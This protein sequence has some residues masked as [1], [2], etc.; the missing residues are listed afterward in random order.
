MREK[1]WI[2]TSQERILTV[3]NTLVD[4][5]YVSTVLNSKF[6]Q[7]SHEITNTISIFREEEMDKEEGFAQLKGGRDCEFGQS[8]FRVHASYDYFSAP[9]LRTGV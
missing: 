8:D 7:Q 4:F 3:V 5:T 2:R 6:L 1:T 9:E